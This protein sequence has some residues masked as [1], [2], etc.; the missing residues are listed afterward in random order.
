MSVFT[1]ADG[2][3][4]VPARLAICSHDASEGLFSL[5][6]VATVA[7]VADDGAQLEF[8]SRPRPVAQQTRLKAWLPRVLC[9]ERGH[10]VGENKKK[11]A[12]FNTCRHRGN[13]KDESHCSFVGWDA[14]S[15]HFGA[16]LFLQTY[17]SGCLYS[18]AFESTVSCT[19][20]EALC[21]S[22]E[23]ADW[24]WHL[25]GPRSAE[26]M[27]VLLSELG[28][29]FEGRGQYNTHTHKRK[30]TPTGVQKLDANTHKPPLDL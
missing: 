10:V 12:M 21:I 29:A 16:F 23:I 17:R 7:V 9:V 14:F 5:Q 27:Q 22:W 28:R 1:S 3:G 30:H 15:V 6:R 2:F 19:A 11:S 18:P 13:G 8:G 4:F 25:S 20:A 24:E 26:G